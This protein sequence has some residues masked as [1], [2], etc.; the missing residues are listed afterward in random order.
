MFILL[1]QSYKLLNNVC[2]YI[3]S[4]SCLKIGR[5]TIPHLETAHHTP[6]SCEC[7]GTSCTSREFS[8]ARRCVFWEFMYYSFKWNQASS[9]KIL[10]RTLLLYCS[11]TCWT[12]SSSEHTSLCLVDA[13]HAL[14]WLFMHVIFFLVGGQPCEQLNEM[15]IL[16][17]TGVTVT[18]GETVPSDD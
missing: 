3:W 17:V 13:T 8:A 4:H 11:W 1:Q 16:A 2:I 7:Q 14:S 10:C 5:P 6:T 18:Y 15:F 9:V 12:N